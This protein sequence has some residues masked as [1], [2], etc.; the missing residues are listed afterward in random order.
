MIYPGNFEK[1]IGFDTVRK[2]LAEACISD[3]GKYYVEKIRFSSNRQTIKRL[4]DQVTEFRRIIDLNKPFPLSGYFDLRYE[5]N[6]L[7]TEGTY[8]AVEELFNLKT[9]LE[10]VNNIL[11]FFKNQPED[12]YPELKSLTTGFELNA[13]ILKEAVRIIDDKGDIK[14]TASPRLSEIRTKISNKQRQVIAETRKA[15]AQAKQN[16]YLPEGSEI[17]IRNGRA[18]IPVRA[19]DK[20]AVKG[21]VHDESATGQTVFIEPVT[22][23]ELNNEIIELENAEKREI[24][25]ILS[26]FSNFL[27]PEIPYLIPVYR[28]LGIIDFIRAKALVA[29]KFNSSTPVIS[30]NRETELINAYHPLLV[31]SHKKLGKDVVPLNISLDNEK[32]ILI[33]SGPNA[34]GK[35][36]CLKT[37]GLLQYM[38]QCGMQIPASPD[39]KLAVF[40][41]IFLD[42]G[43]EQ[44]LENDLST[45]SSHLL[46]MKYFLKNANSKTLILIDE[47]GTG[48]EPQLGAAIAEATLEQLAHKGA[49]GI[50]TT[51]YTNLKLAADK[52]KGLVNGAMLFDTEKMQPLYQLKIGKPGSSFA[53]EIAKKIGF[54]QDVLNRARKKSGGKHLVFDKQLQQLETDKLT[55]EEKQKQLEQ[56]EHEITD[57]QNKYNELLSKLEKEKKEIIENAKIE[58]LE[59]LENS[60][61]EIE[62]TI[63]GIKEAK[64]GKTQTKTLR[65]NLE[66]K[67]S[68]LE[69]E[70]KNVITA[71]TVKNK[72]KT[73]NLKI[74]TGDYVEME[75]MDVVGE[76]VRIEGEDVSVNV[77]NVILNTS[78]KKL[79]KTAKKPETKAKKASKNSIVNNLNEKAANF[80]L[81]IDLRGK[82]GEEALEILTRYI[83]DAILLNI[84][85]VSIL[86]GKGYGILRDLIR[87]YLKTVDQVKWFGD[88]HIE[89]G[90]AGITR[91]VFR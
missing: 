56:K 74:E 5:L 83:D 48:T 39:S 32:R 47:F 4:I 52:I 66:K 38:F 77:N 34:G 78:L 91:V 45:Y 6:R 36:V 40:E 12:E 9:S 59:I 65:N 51:H 22:S 69:K 42:I 41:N 55:I 3:L 64:A 30:A 16:G 90:G 88:A 10:T 27:R 50:I 28:F 2:Y 7:K 87:D 46:N 81:S 15:F 43:D 24:I 49:Y 18:V 75:G 29:A 35:S 17:T 68:E 1:K 60:N 33:I 72:S 19:S 31:I 23:F 20:R 8:I 53:F 63:K 76:V 79:V 80:N 11:I 62:K 58:A 70:L 25:K 67:K 54:P 44:S 71:K 57:L 21:F 13:A 86:H 37:M 73:E 26:A 14:D 85:E 61:K 89:R 84:N 82:R